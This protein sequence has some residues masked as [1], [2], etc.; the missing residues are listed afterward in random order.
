MGWSHS[1][2]RLSGSLTWQEKGKEQVPPA[3]PQHP[4]AAWLRVTG[5]VGEPKQSPTPTHSQ[6]TPSGPPQGQ[7]RHA[8]SSPNLADLLRPGRGKAVLPTIDWS[9]LSG[10]PSRH[11]G[12]SSPPPPPPRAGCRSRSLNF[13]PPYGPSP[14]GHTAHP[15]AFAPPPA[16]NRKRRQRTEGPPKRRGKAGAGGGGEPRPQPARPAPSAAGPAKAAIPRPSIVFKTGL[17]EN[18]EHR[19]APRCLLLKRQHKPR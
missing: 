9:F 8:G 17:Q 5:A 15:W 10:S 3:V 7:V 19:S 1:S 11:G 14:L 6:P 18:L 16:A 13:A 2:W 4:T 12:V